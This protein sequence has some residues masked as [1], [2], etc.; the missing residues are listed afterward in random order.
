[1][2]SHEINHLVHSYGLVLVF[3]F[4]GLQALGLPVPGG[5]AIAAAALY[6]ATAHG[7]PIE[8]V[9]AAGALGALVGTM[10]AFALGRW[11]GE[12]LLIWIGR[13]LRQTPERIGHFRDEFAAHG[14]AWVLVGRF[15]TGIRNLVGLAAGASG[16]R[17]VRFLI[18]SAV[19]ATLW[20]LWTGLQVYFIG[21]TLLGASTWVQVVLVCFGILWMLISLN[22][23]RRRAMRRIARSAPE[24]S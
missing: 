18:L 17:L 12:S 6:A 4:A 20:S 13:R 10:A 23:L 22:F 5:T 24:V 16:M 15:I 8:G 14:G 3:G 11:R 1:M 21:H 9:I 7:L 2:S 19:A